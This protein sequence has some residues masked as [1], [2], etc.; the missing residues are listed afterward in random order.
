L[1]GGAVGSIK[2]SERRETPRISED[3]EGSGGTTHA[4]AESASAFS[5]RARNNICDAF[6]PK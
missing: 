4:P 3:T 2:E 5:V 1:D 6:A